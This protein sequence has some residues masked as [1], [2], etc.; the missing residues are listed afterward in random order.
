MDLD[1]LRGALALVAVAADEAGLIRFDGAVGSVV[2][3]RGK[4]MMLVR[5]LVFTVWTQTKRGIVA[6]LCVC[7]ETSLAIYA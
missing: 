5:L 3:V 1:L 6:L 2:H 4:R 7:K